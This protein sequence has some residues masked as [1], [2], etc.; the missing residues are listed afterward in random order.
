MKNLS[1]IIVKNQIYY[2]KMKF[3]MKERYL[4]IINKVRLE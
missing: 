4:S 1:K 2:L 3:L